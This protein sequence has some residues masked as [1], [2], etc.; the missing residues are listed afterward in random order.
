MILGLSETGDDKIYLAL[1]DSKNDIFMTE[2]RMSTESKSH[3]GKKILYAII[4]GLCVLVIILSTTGIIGVWAIQRPLNNTVDSLVQVVVTA[5]NTVTQ[6]TAKVDQVAAKF[7][8][9]TTQVEDA[10]AQIAQNVTDKGLVLTLLPEEQE[11]NLV[12][13]ATEVSDT[14]QSIKG[15]I[16]AALELYQSINSIPFVNLPAPSEDQVN[17]IE[18]SV[19]QTQA[20]AETMRTS[21]AD[22]RSGVTEK[23]DVVTTTASSLNSE[24]QSI[25]DRLSQLNSKMIALSEFATRVQ[26]SISGILITIAMVLTLLMAFVI[27]TQIEVI[28]LYI[29]RWRLLK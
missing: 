16:T 6:S 5:S 4:I 7:Q 22:F 27:F 9:V 28:R 3:L 21:I 29:A 12:A 14:F 20:L 18:T 23:I 15:S 19:E 11:Q 25:R 2:V 10:S 13:T 26:Q 17:K 1:L 8:E 24:I